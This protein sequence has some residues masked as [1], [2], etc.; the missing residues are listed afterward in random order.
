MSVFKRKDLLGIYDLSLDEINEI[1][2]VSSE[3]KQVLQRPIKKVPTLRDK[4]VINLFYEP[5]TKTRV[6]LS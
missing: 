3:F 1:L 4:T 6:F 5:S 2:E